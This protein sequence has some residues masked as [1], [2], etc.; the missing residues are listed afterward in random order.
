MFLLIAIIVFIISSY[1]QILQIIL[2]TRYT[3]LYFY[4]KVRPNLRYVVSN[5]RSRC[6]HQ[7]IMVMGPAYSSIVN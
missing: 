3:T 1:I 5:G 4:D 2:M 7:D 6:G